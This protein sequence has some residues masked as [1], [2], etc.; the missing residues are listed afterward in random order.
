RFG[1]DAGLELIVHHMLAGRMQLA[2]VGD[3]PLAHLCFS[4]DLDDGASLRYGDERRM[5]KVYMVN[6]G[7]REGIPGWRE[8]GI[9]ILS[10]GFTREAF[11]KLFAGRRDQIRVFVMDQAA[12]SALGNACADEVLFAAGIHPKTPCARLDEERRGRLFDAIRGVI[13]WGIDEVERAGRP[14]EVKVRDHVKVKNRLGQPCPVCGTVIRRVGVHGYDSFFCPR[15]Q[16]AEGTLGGK[17]GI[18]W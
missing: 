12:L 8:Q 13:A 10:P 15:C 7:A 3:R 18:P 1:P 5:G 6:E 2:R 4:L 16:P 11:E 17:Q 14:L 9:D